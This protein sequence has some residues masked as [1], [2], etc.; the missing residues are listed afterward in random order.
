MLV[1]SLVWLGF[2]VVVHGLGGE[3]ELCVRNSDCANNC[4]SIEYSTSDGKYKCTPG[5]TK[6]TGNETAIQAAAATTTVA[7]SNKTNTTSGTKP[8]W[9]FCDVNAECAN[10][11][12]SNEYSTSDGKFKCTPGGAKCTGD[13][14]LKTNSTMNATQPSNSTIRLALDGDTCSAS[15]QC[16]SNCCSSE[17][18][19]DKRLICIASGQQCQSN[20]ITTPP[21]TTT[22]ST[23][24][25][26]TSPVPTSA[27]IGNAL[28][29]ISTAVA[30]VVATM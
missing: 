21:T 23:T 24:V 3:W 19:T 17:K 27:S 13:I 14:G 4:C 30:V 7:P 26:P 8:E 11:C 9:D 10:N 5:S 20:T 29:S 2:S 22:T 18:S 12:C 28:A 1:K 25:K 6:C 15:V 16:Q